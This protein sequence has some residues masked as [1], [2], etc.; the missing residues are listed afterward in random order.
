MN[1][2][3]TARLLLALVLPLA[4]AEAQTKIGA[5]GRIEP[6]GGVLQLVG[7]GDVVAAVPVRADQTVKKGT[8]LVE[9]LGFAA[10][11][12][13]LQLARIA[14]REAEA[15][16]PRTVAAR[17]RAVETLVRELALARDRLERYEK[18][19]ES[20]IAPQE[21]AARRHAV[22]ATES[23]LTGARDELAQAR[24]AT[25]LALERARL[26]VAAAEQRTVRAALRAPT[27]GTVLELLAAPG[28]A[29]GGVL[30]RFAD[31]S[32]MVV[33]AEVFEVDLPKVK[34]GARG[35]AEHRVFPKKLGGTVEQV[36]R[37]VNAQTKSA[38]VRLALDAAEDAARFLGLEVTVA[39]VP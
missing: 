4:A 3:S 19:A 34:T 28:E 8:V 24:L 30:V 36:G 6:A 25:E 26:Q 23:N 31:L 15:A 20:S 2:I 16:G 11:E 27:D 32:R 12:A 5:L 18:L 33:V 10:A 17:E 37:Q 21:L 35:E 7:G 22:H 14:L 29:G 9:F 13:D 38:K 1:P 39:I